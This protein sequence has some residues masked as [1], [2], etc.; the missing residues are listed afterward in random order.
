MRE[1]LPADDCERLQPPRRPPAREISTPPRAHRAPPVGDRTTTV[2]NAAAP[3][4]AVG[5]LAA[6]FRAAWRSQCDETSPGISGG[7]IETKGSRS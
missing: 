7:E 1:Q 5:R 6:P 2:G 3:K 4:R